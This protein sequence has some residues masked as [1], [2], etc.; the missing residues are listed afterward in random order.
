MGD[1]ALLW[2]AQVCMVSQLLLMLLLV[3]LHVLLLA[4]ATARSLIPSLLDRGGHYQPSNSDVPLKVFLDTHRG[5]GCYAVPGG[6]VYPTQGD[7]MG[8]DAQLARQPITRQWG[9]L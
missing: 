2:K 1:K 7:Q 4:L 8:T 6:Y 5:E 9:R 3:L